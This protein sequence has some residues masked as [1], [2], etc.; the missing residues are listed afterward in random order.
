MKV[1]LAL[2]LSYGDPFKTRIDLCEFDSVQQLDD[3][4]KKFVN[5]DEI[6]MLFRS[7]LVEFVLESRFDKYYKETEKGRPIIRLVSYVYFDN[8]IRYI[9]I[10]Y[11]NEQLSDGINFGL[12]RTRLEEDSRFDKFIREYDYLLGCSK[13]VSELMRQYHNGKKECKIRLL[14]IFIKRLT[15]L[16]EEELYFYIRTLTNVCDLKIKNRSN[17]S[18]LSF[19]SEEYDG[20]KS[21]CDYIDEG[22]DDNYFIKLIDTK[23]YEELFDK[24]SLEKILVY[25]RDDNNPLGIRRN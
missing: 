9:P 14:D 6:K 1:F 5:S 19:M 17:D 20:F 21:S 10:I 15:E 23:N 13:E 22:C 18:V 25:S 3:Y 12:I 8:Q 24:Y 16:S 7:D 11:K 2:F 4:T